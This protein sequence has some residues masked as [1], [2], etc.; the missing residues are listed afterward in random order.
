MKCRHVLKNQG[1]D[2]GGEAV[3]WLSTEAFERKINKV[4]KALALGLVLSLSLTCKHALI[5]INACLRSL[6]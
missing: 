1:S 2:D 4:T 6:C 3:E 5:S